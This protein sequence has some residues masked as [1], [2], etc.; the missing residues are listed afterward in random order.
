MKLER[1]EKETRMHALLPGLK[2][3]LNYH[4]LFVHFPIALWLAALLFELLSFVGGK[5]EEMHR[6]ASWLLYLGTLAGVVTVLTGL[7]AEDS[8]PLGPARGVMEFHEEMML[9]T[10]ALAVALSGFAYFF[11]HRFTKKLRRLFL[12]GLIVLG[13]L[14]TLGADRGAEMVYQYGVSVNWSHAL[15][16]K[17]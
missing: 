13:V 9:T 3:A 17:R 14:M 1:R 5:G 10:F 12:V 8:V 6:V 7:A 15:Q 11:Q 2:S 16:Q 4:P